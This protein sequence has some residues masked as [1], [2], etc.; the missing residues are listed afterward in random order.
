MK[1]LIYGLLAFAFIAT[2]AT[3][4]SSAPDPQLEQC[5]YA[6]VQV[7]EKNH[8]ETSGWIEYMYWD[9]DGNF[10]GKERLDGTT[11]E[12]LFD[13]YAGACVEPDPICNLV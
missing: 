11:G 3:T 9:Y 8:L 6:E 13:S 12:C 10:L 1:K 5:M 2:I 4:A 7:F